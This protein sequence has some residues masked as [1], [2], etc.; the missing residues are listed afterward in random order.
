MMLSKKLQNIS[1]RKD[2]S[3]AENSRNKLNYYLIVCEGK[4][5]EP[6][7]FKAFQKQL[8]RGILNI[9][10][11]GTGAETLKIVN[12]AENKNNESKRTNRPY[13][14]V[15]AVFDRD[16][17][18]PCDFNKA[19]KKAVSKGFG[20]AWSNEAFELWFILHFEYCNTGMS[21]KDYK[22]KLTKLLGKE[23]KK[24]DPNIY[25][26]L[27]EHQGTAISN[28]E[29]LLKRHKGTAPSSLNPATTVH[30]LVKELN[31]YLKE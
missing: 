22:A 11:L 10:V 20:C 21:R 29:K 26:S 16:S 14:K 31:E 17:F 6:N 7:Y 24:N 4:K 23:Y 30:L 19:I 2:L 9:D 18:P 15:W 1:K 8:P 13:D 27:K 25:E 3:R 12:I 28:S 5:T